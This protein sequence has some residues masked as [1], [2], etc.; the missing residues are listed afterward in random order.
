KAIAKEFLV[1]KD[2]LAIFFGN[3]LFYAGILS[4]LF[5]LLLTTRCLRKFGITTTLFVLPVAVFAGSMGLLAFGTLAAGVVL[6][7]SDQVLR[8]SL[9]KSTAELL[10]LPLPGRLKLQVKWFIDTVIWR[11]GDGVSGLAVLLFATTLHLPARQIS[12]IVLVLV[13]GWLVAVSVARRQYVATL[14]ESI[15]QHRV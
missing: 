13:S 11:L 4:L 12:W 8:Y 6:K 9:D 1:N 15:S 10:Y 7:G 2:A 14:K 5:Q 3:F